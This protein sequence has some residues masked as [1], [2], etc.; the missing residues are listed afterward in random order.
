MYL[1]TLPAIAISLIAYYLDILTRTEG[2]ALSGVIL[3]IG[4]EWRLAEIQKA[5]T[6]ASE[7]LRRQ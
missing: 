1:I 5:L 6:E 4:V 2:I 3:L 7:R